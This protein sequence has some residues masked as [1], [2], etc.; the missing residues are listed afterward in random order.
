[1]PIA[2]AQALTLGLNV[3]T[4]GVDLKAARNVTFATETVYD[5]SGKPFNYLILTG[6]GVQDFWGTLANPA[7]DVKYTLY[8]TG[9]TDKRSFFSFILPQS[10]FKVLL[11]TKAKAGSYKRFLSPLPGVLYLEDA[12]GRVWDVDTA[13]PV[14][15]TTLTEQRK[16]QISIFEQ[17]EKDG[18]L[19]GIKGD[20]DKLREEAAKKGLTQSGWLPSLDEVT[21]PDG[22]LNAQKIIEALEN[23]INA[24]GVRPMAGNSAYPYERGWCE[25][26]FCAGLGFAGVVRKNRQAGDITE[27]N[28][29]KYNVDNPQDKSRCDGVYQSR[30]LIADGIVEGDPLGNNQWIN[31][32]RYAPSDGVWG[33]WDFGTSGLNP[34]DYVGCG[35]LA[36]SSPGMA[37]TARLSTMWGVAGQTSTW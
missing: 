29:N 25:G 30:C 32:Y 1:M 12:S 28:N 19:N 16:T 20:W 37:F 6:P 7:P 34:L 14:N 24:K 8:A 33:A 26:W 23:Q 27:L 22:N 9:A 35:P 18:I 17:R 3:S 4:G 31:S 11:D 5:L 2:L 13:Q 15:P 10:Y 21:L 36:V